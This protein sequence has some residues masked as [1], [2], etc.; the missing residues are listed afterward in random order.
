MKNKTQSSLFPVFAVLFIDNLG[1]AMVFATFGEL[2]SSPD[3]GL[4]KD[5][6][7]L[8]LRNLMLSC[9]L[10]QAHTPWVACAD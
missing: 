7:S 6:M 10:E 8:T 1:F 2:F 4:V 5:G 9:S 3:Y